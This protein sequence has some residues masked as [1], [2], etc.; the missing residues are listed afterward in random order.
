MIL[1]VDALRFDF[2][3][4]R[5]PL[6]IGSRLF[7]SSSEEQKQEQEQ[8]QSSDGYKQKKKGGGHPNL[9]GLL[10]IHPP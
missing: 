10:P 5:L 7:L 3:R 6:S 1:V 8:E 4:D 2:A 9:Y